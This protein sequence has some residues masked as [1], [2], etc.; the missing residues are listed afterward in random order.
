MS[1]SAFAIDRLRWSYTS[2]RRICFTF[3]SLRE[4]FLVFLNCCQ[5]L[6]LCS[7]LQLSYYPFLLDAI[8]VFACH[9]TER[10]G[11]DCG[12]FVTLMS[13]GAFSGTL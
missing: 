2:V 3:E 7:M 10:K 4:L 6:Q 9:L 8:G 1:K 13:E 12:V 5:R 11:S